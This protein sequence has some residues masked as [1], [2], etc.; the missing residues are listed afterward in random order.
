MFSFWKSITPR[1]GSIGIVG[2]VGSPQY[3][4]P[5]K[6]FGSG[7]FGSKTRPRVGAKSSAYKWFG[8]SR[9][10]FLGTHQLLKNRMFFVYFSLALTTPSSGSRLKKSIS[11]QVSPHAMGSDCQPKHFFVKFRNLPGAKPD[12][13]VEFEQERAREH[14][15]LSW[16]PLFWSCR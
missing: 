4:L 3:S 6:A 10:F 7:L 11:L 15:F 8:S 9:L 2:S 5:V 14:E 13:V 1:F 12:N 16:V